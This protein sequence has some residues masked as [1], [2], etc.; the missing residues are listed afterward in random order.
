MK[1]MVVMLQKMKQHEISL[2]E[3]L[4]VSPG[5]A[6]LLG[7]L[8]HPDTSQRISMAGGCGLRSILLLKYWGLVFQLFACR[9]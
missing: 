6:D 2:P 7:R 1:G 4:G 5:C 8:L 3:Q 9:P